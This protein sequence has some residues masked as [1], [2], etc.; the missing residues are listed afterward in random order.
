[1]PA[2]S[3]IRFTNIIYEN[4]AKRFND[5]IFEFEGHNGVI[6]LENGGGKTVLI[7]TALQAILPHSDLGERKIRDTLSLEGG[8]G[9]IAIEWILND[10]PRRYALTA[11]TLFLSPS[12]L[13]SLRYAYDYPAGDN[14]SIEEM[15]FV[16]KNN[17]GEIR[18]S[19]RQEIQEYYQ[20]MQGQY[21]NAHTFETIKGFHQYIEDEFH[22]IPAEWRNIARINGAEGDVEKFFEACNTESQLVDKLLIPVVEEAMAG[23]GSKDF[24]AIFERQRE[25]FKKHKELRSG[26]EESKNIEER[27]GHYVSTYTD[28]HS[29]E[30][31][32]LGKRGEAKTLYGL[33]EKAK[34][35]STEELNH[36]ESLQDALLKD[37]E[38]LDRKQDSYEIAII[39]EELG[40]LEGEYR[41][42]LDEFLE[43]DSRRKDREESFQNLEIA[44]GKATIK[45][46]E[47]AIE[48]IKEQLETLDQD[49]NILD[50][51]ERLEVNSGILAG[52]F[53][54]D[55]EELDRQ[56]NTLEAQ[57][58]RF[59]RELEELRRS[60]LK[61]E[62]D[63]DNLNSEKSRLEGELNRLKED[64]D[65][66]KRRI[67]DSPKNETVEGEYPKWEK[68]LMETEELKV[69]YRNGLSSLEKRQGQIS[70][71]IDE[72][73]KA[74]QTMAKEE[75]S[76]EQALSFIDENHEKV[77][78]MVRNLRCEW[79][80]LES[81]Y[82]KQE[83]IVGYIEEKLEITKSQRE[84]LL[85]KERLAYRLLDYYGERDYF[86]AEPL[87]EEWV[88]NWQ[89]QFHLLETGTRFIDNAAKSLEKSIG[90]I[91]AEFP[92]WALAIITTE[93]EISR[94][95]KRLEE[96][97]KRITS[98]ILILSQEE[99]TKILTEGKSI[100][101]RYIYPALWENN[102][103]REEFRL[104][105][106]DLKESV[107]K[108]VDERKDKEKEENQWQ[109]IL[110]TTLDYLSMYP[111]DEYNLLLEEL[112][113][114][115]FRIEENNN[116]LTGKEKEKKEIE[117]E[118]KSIR[119]KLRTIEDESM[120][121]V[122]KIDRALEY[123]DKSKTTKTIEGYI[124]KKAEAL[125]LLKREISIS[126]KEATIKEE[127][128]SDV[129]FNI[130]ELRSQIQS[131][132]RDPDY[133]KVKN[134]KAID[135]QKDRES[136]LRERR[137]LED[138][139]NER[140]RDRY[141]LE[142]DLKRET[143]E[144]ENIGAQ[145]RRK[146]TQAEYPIDEEFTFPYN[147]RILMD[148]LVEELKDLKGKIQVERPSLKKREDAFKKQESL[149]EYRSK[150]FY[151]RFEE[152]FT[153]IQPLPQVKEQLS[154]EK[155]ELESKG[156]YL[157]T[158]C[159]RLKAELSDIEKNI[160]TLN[161]KNGRYDF[162]SGAIEE[163]LIP[164]NIVQDL[165]YN[166]EEIILALMEELEALSQEVEKQRDVV[167]S[168]R[169][170][171]VQFANNNVRDIRL[172]EMAISGVRNKN[173]FSEVLEWQ[174]NMSKTLNR[175]I[176]I[177]EKNIAEHDKELNQFIQF[178]YTHL[179]T[180]AHEIAT[181]PKNTRVRVEDS[182]KEIYQIQVPTWS[183]EE[184]KEEIR[185]HVD[186]MIETM[187][188]DE[189][190]DHEGQ[191]D[192]GKI[193]KF[194]EKHLES[195]Q[196]LSRVIGFNS[197]KV[198]CRKVTNDGKVSSMYYTWENS[199]K[200]SGG[201]KWSKNMALFLGLLN[202]SAEK[203][204]HILPSQRKHR[205]VIMDNPFGK[206]SSDHVLNPVF[207]IADQLGF[208]FIALTAHGEG[209]F[210][211][212]YFPVVYSCKLRP[213]SGASTS[214]LTKEKIMNYAYFMD[215]DPMT[216][217]RLG[218]RE[219]LSLFE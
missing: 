29:I 150:D 76:R 53:E 117:D 165:P 171:F 169:N 64:M 216:I 200:W 14:Y 5:D 106:R 62:K 38:E 99:A 118:I 43:L 28:L 94:L 51:R 115:R 15:P 72:N 166:R 209:R 198:K 24:V 92:L 205:T 194:I 143:Q 110:N 134:C 39:K 186:W 190:L 145:L 23:S 210:I 18:P 208:Q 204:Q 101:E 192:L 98:P 57:G 83:S 112:K 45:Q 215:N 168:E 180:L 177:Y 32:M 25:H 80:H 174:E 153:F 136:I 199:N 96:Y 142:G 147:G 74:G 88:A 218:D 189:F 1:M 26:I 82:Q 191:E 128:I 58:K 135:S 48:L 102:V 90:E 175:V 133:L 77:L 65:R 86:T 17:K 206:A 195:K 121:L 100:E 213:A 158:S 85:E 188:G 66:I 70:L 60:I 49:Q 173:V 217:E 157:E 54:R 3:R 179:S 55:R 164:G 41:L 119:E 107:G 132:I 97:N 140:Q 185:R 59:S 207:F 67:L 123:L 182:W 105:K 4:G 6:L 20:Y 120:T 8:A 212:D 167:D 146:Y 125:T 219:Q 84:R 130:S 144:R 34:D 10:R 114:L 187:E 129:D 160:Q 35:T 181:I 63:R 203:K 27:I 33:L 163:S 50:L 139:L 68:R 109:D 127:I 11:V 141:Q 116:E 42:K 93:G 75:A 196:I 13:R 61:K 46:K 69:D 16:I 126:K 40:V 161:I 155:I 22:I 193:K 30:E 19:S 111:F 159:Q 91:Y 95:S 108:V 183:E 124:L 214:I 37:R 89:N 176:M 52:L 36:I 156:K 2:I 113:D 73:H 172:R 137:I 47:E 81:I 12:G 154:Q 131:I 178:L 151:E 170:K 7:Q 31:K 21:L 56:R 149:L 9:H 122:N 104:W 184:G 162:L 211:R 79:S 87:L 202:Y 201:E 197:I 148:N 78:S 152:L 138:T 71:E 103:D 44:E